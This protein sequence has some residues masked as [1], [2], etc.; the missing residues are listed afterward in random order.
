MVVVDPAGWPRFFVGAVMGPASW[1]YFSVGAIVGVAISEAMDLAIDGA[2][3][4][5]IDVT[6]G[7]CRLFL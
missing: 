5:G 3:L 6:I 1:P 7:F 4:M 2:I